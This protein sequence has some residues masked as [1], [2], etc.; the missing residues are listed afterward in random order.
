MTT[1]VWRSDGDLL[2]F[3]FVNR[4]FRTGR[5]GQRYGVVKGVFVKSLQAVAIEID[6]LQEGAIGALDDEFDGVGLCLSTFSSHLDGLYIVAA[7]IEHFL[8]LVAFVECDGRDGEHTH[9]Q[10]V[11]VVK[12]IRCKASQRFAIKVDHFEVCIIRCSH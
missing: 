11:H 8:M 7:Y 1:G 4:D 9:R 3:F 2:A 10:C 6:H 5:L 12:Y